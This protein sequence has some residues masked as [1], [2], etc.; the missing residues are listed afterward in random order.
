M[1]VDVCACTFSLT[2]EP[3]LTGLAYACFNFRYNSLVR[4][5]ETD[6]SGLNKLELL[7]LH[8]NGIHTIPAKTFSD[9]QALQVRPRRGRCRFKRQD[10]PL[11][12]DHSSG[13]QE[14]TSCALE[15]DIKGGCLR[16]ISL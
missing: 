15:G 4:L 6:F 8:S 11:Y 7:M 1:C 13:T 2:S 14:S 16:L 3:Q 5:T 9:L 12:T 10:V